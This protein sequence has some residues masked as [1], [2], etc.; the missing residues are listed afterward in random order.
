MLRGLLKTLWEKEKML[1]TSIFSLSHN[2]LFSMFST[3][4]KTNYHFLAKLNLWSANA[5]NLVSSNILSFGKDLSKLKAV[6]DNYF[7]VAQLVPCFFGRL[8]NIVVKGE[9]CWL[10]VVFSFSH[11][12]LKRLPP[13]GCY[14]TG[15]FEESKVSCNFKF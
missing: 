8:E 5:F 10:P 6:K 9:K 11:I 14:N 1:V 15:L 12:S 2:V 3:L 7:I 4:S 13:R